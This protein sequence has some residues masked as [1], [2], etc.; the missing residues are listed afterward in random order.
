MIRPA[1]ADID[2][3]ALRHNLQ[4]VRRAA[5]ASRV[6]AVI[7]AD[8][9]GHG[10]HA[11]AGALG[12]A[13]AFAVAF[14]SEA[15]YLRE[16]GIRK[17]LVALQG[18]R[19]LE[20]LTAAAAHDIWLVMHHLSQLR[21]LETARLS[22]AV[23]VWLKVDSGMHRLGFPAGELIR[24]YNAVKGLSASG[25]CPGL[26][27]HLACADERKNPYTQHQIRR[28]DSAVADLEGECSIAN[29]AAI[30]GFPETHRDWVR[31][32]IM[33]YGASPFVDADASECGLS[34]VMT[35]SAPLISVQRHRSGDAIGYGGDYIC[36][37]DMSIGIAAIGYGDGYPRHAPS[38]TPVLIN[39][40]RAA[41]AG[42]VSM[43]MIT[44][45]LRGIDRPKPGDEV[46]LW[47]EGL[48]I[49]E[50]ARH[51]G[52]ISYELFCNAG[53]IRHEVMAAGSESIGR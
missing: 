12:D 42:R 11:A 2:L 34:P 13:D 18:C 17:P 47:G 15:L 40:R 10:M 32:G 22:S 14:V 48:P 3:Q 36:P 7:K 20:E 53:S 24:V 25:G 21:L 26:L 51:A 50:V 28:F 35:L 45:D 38:G 6:M 41:L 37:Q 16:V 46:V 19:S 31:P 33:L 29:S 30:L 52:T 27:T 43:D 39:G 5:P 23:K 9:Y 1:K 49:D 4:C 44:I 8:A